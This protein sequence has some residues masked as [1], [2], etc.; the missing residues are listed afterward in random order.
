MSLLPPAPRP[1][2]APAASSS[3]GGGA[4]GGA[5]NHNSASIAS[6]SSPATNA[7]TASNNTSSSSRGRAFAC[8]T[9]DCRKTFLRLEHL[10]RHQRIHTGEKPFVCALPSC[11]K[12]FGRNDELL[13]H[14]RLHA[15]RQSNLAS[16]GGNGGV[17]GL[18]SAETVSVAGAGAAAAAAAWAAGDSSMLREWKSSQQPLA[19][20]AAAAAS[21]G[22]FIQEVPMTNHPRLQ[23]HKP[24]LHPY[25]HHHLQQQQQQH[26]QH[27]HQ[28]PAMAHK[29]LV[30]PTPFTPVQTLS[31]S[32]PT[33]HVPPGAPMSVSGTFLHESQDRQL[34]L[35]QQYQ[36]PMFAGQRATGEA[37][38]VIP[39]PL[40]PTLT[41]A[42]HNPQMLEQIDPVPNASAI[43][44]TDA[45]GRAAT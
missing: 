41:F 33:R 36:F 12:R 22:L 11:G 9:P 10:T 17:S 16:A 20:A 25:H 44:A 38:S 26:H 21:P 39:R 43:S 28:Q 30:T 14:M 32:P 27:Q 31:Q 7:N 19:G 18:E 2:V 5:S 6:S 3:D 45:N 35:Q 1:P 15:K 29:R 23:P 8:P 34:Q 4:G 24:A 40:P 37:S 13:R 42:N